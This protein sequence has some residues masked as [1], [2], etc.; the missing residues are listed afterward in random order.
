MTFFSV[1]VCLEIDFLK[2]NFTAFG[3][4]FVDYY[5]HGGQY[6]TEIKSKKH[7][8]MCIIHSADSSRRFYPDSGSSGTL[9]PAIFVYNAGRAFA[10]REIRGSQCWAVRLFRACRT[11]HICRGR[12][13]LVFFKTKLWLHNRICDWKLCDGK[14][15]RKAGRADHG[16]NS[17][18]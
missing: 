2:M 7:G 16:K 10:W 5:K 11:S 4:N 18:R 6:E 17:C 1:R 13:S 9:Y 3:M 8:I 12:R 14:D 15:D